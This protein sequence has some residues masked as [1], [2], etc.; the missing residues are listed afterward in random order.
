MNRKE[1]MRNFRK[2]V[3]RVL[4]RG[5]KD[6]LKKWLSL[7]AWVTGSNSIG[8]GKALTFD[9]IKTLIKKDN[10]GCRQYH[11]LCLLYATLQAQK[12]NLN[13]ITVIELG[14]AGGGDY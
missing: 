5:V 14:V 2:I 3:S 8:K 13:S 10:L 7:P 6:W 9:E 11:A 12:M 1:S 4:P